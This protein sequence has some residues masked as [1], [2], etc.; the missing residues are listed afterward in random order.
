MYKFRYYINLQGS[1]ICVNNIC[2]G[3]YV[4]FFLKFIFPLI[5]H[6]NCQLESIKEMLPYNQFPAGLL[7][8]SRIIV[9]LY[10]E[11]FSFR[12]DRIKHI[13]TKKNFVTRLYIKF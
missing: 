13:N 9:H 5:M 11:L 12:K 2:G 6:R 10:Y 3:F 8:F 1:K 7:L 4:S